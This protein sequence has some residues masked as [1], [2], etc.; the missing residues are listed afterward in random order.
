[1]AIGRF[2]DSIVIAKTVFLNNKT[3]YTMDWLDTPPGRDDGLPEYTY[4]KDRTHIQAAGPAGIA[5]N[6]ASKKPKIPAGPAA[7]MKMAFSQKVEMMMQVS[8][9]KTC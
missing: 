9:Y 8:G 7:I 5:E 3:R 6:T 1:M 2:V 4:S